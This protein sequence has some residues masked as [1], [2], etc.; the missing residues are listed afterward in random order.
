ME[1]DLSIEEQLEELRRQFVELSRRALGLAGKDEK[2][3][4]D[5]HGNVPVLVCDISGQRLSFELESVAEVVPAAELVE[6]PESPGWVS[7]LLDLRGR[8]IPVIDVAARIVGGSRELSVND[9]FVVCS[10]G[11]RPVALVVQAVLGVEHGKRA[12]SDDSGKQAMADVPHA[13]YL[14][15]ILRVAD[16]LV[17]LISVRRLVALS[18]LPTV[19]AEPTTNE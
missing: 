14:K 7:G 9:H 1:R 2:L 19:E 11:G 8:A 17:G 10:D 6:L 15:A 3:S 18:D 12:S 16:S 5:A 13:P 4:V